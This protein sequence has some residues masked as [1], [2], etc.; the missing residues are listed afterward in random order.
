MSSVFPNQDLHWI[1]QR[2][3]ASV[4]A[5]IDTWMLKT[6]LQELMLV[7]SKESKDCSEQHDY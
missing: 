3:S 1:R 6:S 5:W 4:S 2:R 7:V